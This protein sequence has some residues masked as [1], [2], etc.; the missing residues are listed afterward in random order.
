MSKR[1][2]A[3]VK[4]E[5]RINE[6]RITE[7]RLNIIAADFVSTTGEPLPITDQIMVETEIEIENMITAM[8]GEI[9]R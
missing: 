2:E 6:G 8:G 4:E 3:R 1:M 5:I 7:E 9:I